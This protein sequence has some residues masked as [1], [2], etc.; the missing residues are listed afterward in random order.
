MI[1]LADLSNFWLSL[2]VVFTNVFLSTYP[3]KQHS[4]AVSSTAEVNPRQ[5]GGAETRAEEKLEL[6]L[7]NTARSCSYC[8]FR[9]VK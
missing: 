3:E 6:P 1:I 9:T 5:P 8:V 7:Q 4:S 2:Y